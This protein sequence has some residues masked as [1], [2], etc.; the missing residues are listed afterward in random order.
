M[1]EIEDQLASII[2]LILKFERIEDDGQDIHGNCFG[3]RVGVVSALKSV[4]S[5]VLIVVGY[6]A[7]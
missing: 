5:N 4:C 7:V 2:L 3:Y 6:Q 1:K